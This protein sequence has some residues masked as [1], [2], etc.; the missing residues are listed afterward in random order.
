ELLPTRLP[1]P[2]Y[3]DV[4]LLQRPLEVTEAWVGDA[5]FDVGYAPLR[6]ASDQKP[7][8]AV[9]VPLLHQRRVRERELASALAAVL[10]LYLASLVA[11]VAVGTWLARRLTKPLSDLTEG[12]RRVARGNLEQPVAGAGPDELGEVVGAFNQMQRDL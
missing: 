2:V 10:G 4:I 5:H 11:A 12:A 9:S 6:D 3:R 8:G 1:G 7:I